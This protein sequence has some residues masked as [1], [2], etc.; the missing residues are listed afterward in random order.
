MPG[1]GGCPQAQTYGALALLC[2]CWATAS[3]GVAE[4][5]RLPTT[6]GCEGAVR[7]AYEEAALERVP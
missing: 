7:L 6:G 4:G 3:L 2:L 5:L 1:Q